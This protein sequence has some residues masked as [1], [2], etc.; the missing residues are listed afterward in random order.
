MRSLFLGSAL[1]GAVGISACEGCRSP[2]TPNTDSGTAAATPS[3]RLYLVSDLAG[4]LE[5][6][7][8]VKD[9]LGGMD[10]FGALVT[11]E[12]NIAPYATLSSGP[13][14]FMDMD[15]AEEKQ[16][17][18][19]SKAET[20]ATTLR[21]LKLAAFAPARN[22]WAGG[23]DE[24]KKL[25]EASAAMSL[26]ANVS[27]GARSSIVNVGGVQIGIIGVASP[28]KAEHANGTATLEGVASSP[29]IPAVKEAAAALRDKVQAMIVLA[30]VGRGEA[31]RIADEVPDLLAIVVGSDGA[32]GDENTKAAPP[33]QI[34]GVLV[35]E[36]AN[37][38]QTVGVLDLYVRDAKAGAVKFADGTGIERMRK[39]EELD[40]RID[41]LRARL[42]TWETDRSVLPADIAARKAD[43]ARLS[44]E[45]DALDRIPAPATGSFYRYAMREVRDELGTDDTV[46][47]QMNAYYKKV[48]DANKA[49]L[50]DKLPLPA[51][52]G[53]PTY[54]GVD[55]CT[56][57]HEAPKK[58]WDA[59][60]HAH[61]YATLEKDFKEANLECVGCHVTGYDKPGGSNVTHVSELKD[62]QCEVCHGPG[63]L[64]A[65]DP[66]KAKIPVAHPQPDTCLACHHP[67]HVHTF[68]AAVKMAEILGPGHG[69]PLK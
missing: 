47:S 18:E 63:S 13:L 24:L 44:Q 22:E 32:N 6:C 23:A 34:G 11:K 20:I 37:H 62:V 16:S 52:K 7:G 58:V 66:K 12:K 4:A 27:G 21:T 51:A 9:Q 55:A 36:T 26:A 64:H 3:A 30:A 40:G 41:E 8:C 46:K 17:Q 39:R 54:A 43:V 50:K 49:E 29:A 2:S 42:A 19:V 48:N 57:C 5:P 35:V 33:E 69:R 56:S 59:T 31:K 61:A 1:L 14:F 38:L 68:D 65:A 28:D 53:A 45:R 60:R 25:A 10:K 15:L 67:P